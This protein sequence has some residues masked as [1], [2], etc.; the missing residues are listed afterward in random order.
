M[1]PSPTAVT[2]GT[3]A[4]IR[5][6]TTRSEGPAPH[7]PIDGC[8]VSR[9][10]QRSG[11]SY[12]FV[13]GTPGSPSWASPTREPAT[14]MVAVPAAVCGQTAC[15]PRGR[16]GRYPCPLRLAYMWAGRPD[17]PTTRLTGARRTRVC[18]PPCVLL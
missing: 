5:E 14:E 13:N 15:C 9:T 10:C 4:A 3:P 12:Y 17:Q 7:D 1:P 2:E 18:R 16:G 6:W 11:Q 8:R